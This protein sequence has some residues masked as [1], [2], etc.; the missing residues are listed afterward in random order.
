MRKPNNSSREK[1]LKKIETVR[2]G[3]SSF[4]CITTDYN[5]KLYHPVL[6]DAAACFKKE[7][8]AVNGKCIIC[9]DK[10]DLYFKL[11]E[12]ISERSY[13]YIFCRDTTI[14]DHLK[15]N[16]IA[17]SNHPEE[18]EGMQAGI[19]DCEYLIARTGSV[20]F[21]S[22]SVSGR[23]MHVFPPVHIVAARA[24][25]LVNYPED[26]LISIQQKYKRELPSL[27]T[28]V[29]GP[30]RTADIEKTL[31]LGAHGPKEMIVFL[32]MN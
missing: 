2:T 8:E 23:Q 4:H 26:A 15:E 3:R 7:I 11:K 14:I 22:A 10:N 12:F 6:P 19:T 30:S 20:M 29:T 21:T 32:S 1:I 24:S 9:E 27:L 25:Q 31:V 18:F 17:Y 5:K 28:T 13:P 16:N